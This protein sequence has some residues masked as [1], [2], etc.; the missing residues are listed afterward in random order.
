MARPMVESMCP[1]FTVDH[2]PKAIAFYADQMGFD[3]YVHF[4]G[5]PRG[6]A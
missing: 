4:F 3:G 6:T 1:F 5:R 2:A